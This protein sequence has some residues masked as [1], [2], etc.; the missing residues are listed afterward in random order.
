MGI[1][2]AYFSQ[3]GGIMR[4]RI[5]KQLTMIALAAG[6][7]MPGMAPA[8]DGVILIDP[9]RASSPSSGFLVTISKPGSYRLAGNVTVP[10]ANTT[11]I[12][13]NADNVTIDLNGFSIQ[14]PAHCSPPPVSCFPTGVGNGVHVV[15]RNNIV[16][17][18][19]SIHGV[20]NI[21]IYLE[22]NSARID[23]MSLVSNG[24]G[25]AAFFGGFISDSVAESNGGAGIFGLDIIVSGNLIR[26]NQLFGL[27]AYG[28]SAYTN[29]RFSG[30]NNNAVQVNN[31]PAQTGG[32]LCNAAGCP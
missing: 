23:K 11:A 10:D 13:I 22:T 21:G 4:N 1:P 3:N 27:E 17:T 14:G 19:G 31:K 30:N 26:D 15:N 7:L 29:N 16:V 28:Q 8:V 9:G 25:G 24:R 20:G 18:N 2:A 5:L 6:L 32:N 12:E